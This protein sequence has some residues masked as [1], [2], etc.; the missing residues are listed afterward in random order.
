MKCSLCLIGVS[1]SARGQR[2]S[3]GGQAECCLMAPVFPVWGA[4][5]PGVGGRKSEKQSSG[6]GFRARAMEAHSAEVERRCPASEVRARIR[7]W[8][9]LEF[10]SMFG[11]G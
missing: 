9:R 2:F 7:R 11:L 1:G 5:G 6:S 3:A 4:C 8:L 10:E